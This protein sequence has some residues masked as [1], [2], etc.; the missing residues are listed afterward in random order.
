[1]RGATGIL[2]CLDAAT[3][4]RFWIRN[5][6]TD[7]SAKPPGWG[8]SSS[9][10]VVD[11]KVIVFAG[12]E[13]DRNLL[14]YRTDSGEPAWAARASHDS[15]ASPQLATLGG[16][17][18]CLLLGD[19]GLTAVDP[20]SGDALWQFGWVMAGAPRTVQAHVLG[21]SQLVAGTLSGP[22]VALVEVTQESGQWKVAE[23]WSTTQMKP[24][25]PDFA[26]QGGCAYGFD[27]AIFCC[28]D[29]ASGERRWKKGRYG[30]GQ[31]MSLPEQS[32]LLVVSES[33]ELIL[34]AADPEQ[35]RE[36]G[37]FQA[38]SGKTW[39][40]PV[41]AHG[42]LYVRNDEELACYELAGFSQK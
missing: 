6:A 24:E 18:Q 1:L 2:K 31:V 10:L 7:A 11:D 35:H 15:Y 8:Y 33:G 26:V 21:S 12:G 19:H 13:G 37:R 29:L 23:V 14:A 42:R 20:S 3:G 9:P 30:R 32:L 17:R 5:V 27:G 40:H 4:K 41:I 28:L 38:L 34:L 36:L 16:Q 39:N 25:F 22:G